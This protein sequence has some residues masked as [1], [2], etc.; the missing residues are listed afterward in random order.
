V[1]ADDRKTIWLFTG[2]ALALGV[3]ILLA[4]LEPSAANW[5]VHVLGFVSPGVAAGIVL[6]LIASSLPPVQKSIAA[7]LTRSAEALGAKPRAFRRVLL[8]GCLCAAAG[9]FW[10]ARQHA[11][12]L[13]DG[14]LVIRTLGVLDRTGD[15][16]ASFP[17]APLSGMAAWQ[18]MHLLQWLHAGRAA[19]T[20]WQAASVLSGLVT[21]GAV[22]KLS[23][24][25]WTDPVERSAGALLAGFSG[26]AQLMFGYVETYPAA[27]AI[28]WVYLVAALRVER[29]ET[30]LAVANVLFVILCLL[31]VGMLILLPSLMVLWFSAWR[32]KGWHQLLVAALPA[33]VTAIL[34]LWWLGYG[35]SRLLA[36]ILRDG[37]HYLPLF[38]ADGWNDPYT[39]FS[40]WHAADIM[41]LFLHLAPFSLFMAGAYVVSSVLPWSARPKEDT[42]WYAL[43][44]PAGIWLCVNSFELGLSRDWDLAAPFGVLVVVG[45]LVIWHR[46]TAPGTGRQRVMVLMALFTAALTSGWVALNMD[47]ERSFT[48]FGSLQDSRFWSRSALANANEELGSYL[49]DCGR[50]EEA[51]EAF[52]RSVTLDSTNARRWVQLAGTIA[53]AGDAAAALRAYERA[54]AL[55]TTD[56]MARLNA[57]ILTYQLGRTT[58]G[59]AMVRDCVMRDTASAAA[60]MTLGTMLLQDGS[61]DAEA[62]QWL[63]RAV[64]LDPGLE[65]AGRRAAALR[66]RM[67]AAGKR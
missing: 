65:E 48:R 2:T 13:G 56:P 29:G 8:A 9:L 43:G 25:L 28:L 51:A 41:N 14:F 26:A 1:R 60:A 32:R 52:A 33:A 55:G 58:E 6:L 12:F 34:L 30:H 54:I 45:A 53:Q 36:T 44:F 49:R 3:L 66:A 20:A 17:T 19:L 46:V 5:G 27:Y 59:I 22:W 10:A 57:A 11:F 4:A 62:L 61:M 21:V 23:G 31:H 64:Q 15:I 47:A 7:M 40:L 37:A 50:T 18:L 39:L 63:D 38:S 35:P 42:L 24:M 67:A 16:P